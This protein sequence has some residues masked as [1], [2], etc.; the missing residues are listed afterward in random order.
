MSPKSSKDSEVLYLQEV[1]KTQS[2]QIAELQEQ[3]RHLLTLL[4]PSAIDKTLPLGQPK[5]LPQQSSWSSHKRSNPVKKSHY[6]S[7]IEELQLE[8]SKMICIDEVDND[9]NAQE[10]SARSSLLT[11]SAEQHLSLPE[12]D[13][14]MSCL[15]AQ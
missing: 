11:V 9:S 8:N 2:K 1:I 10:A 12:K 6:A 15:Y 14:A 4:A 3:V 7:A 5:G 13:D